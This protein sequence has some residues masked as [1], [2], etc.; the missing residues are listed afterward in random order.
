[1][2]GRA[3]PTPTRLRKGTPNISDSIPERREKKLAH[4]EGIWNNTYSVANQD[5]ERDSICSQPDDADS[6]DSKDSKITAVSF[7]APAFPGNSFQSVKLTSPTSTKSPRGTVK[8]ESTAC[9]EVNEEVSPVEEEEDGYLTAEE[10]TNA[11][12]KSMQELESS[13][14]TFSTGCETLTSVSFDLSSCS[15]GGITDITVDNATIECSCSFSSMSYDLQETDPESL[16]SLSSSDGTVTRN[17]L[18][19][20]QQQQQQQQQVSSSSSSDSEVTH[21]PDKLLS[22]SGKSPIKSPNRSSGAINHLLPLLV[23]Y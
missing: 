3:N 19:L 6:K 22:P 8:V 1:M 9:P 4:I 18:S 12:Q 15:S 14:R 23:C 17:Y 11:I 16:S 21:Q 13:E 5:S 20:P 2:P 7:A 10:G